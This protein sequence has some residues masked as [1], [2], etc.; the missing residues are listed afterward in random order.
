MV[1]ESDTCTRV[2]LMSRST[3]VEPGS[4]PR[5]GDRGAVL[6]ADGSAEGGRRGR[7]IVVS[8]VQSARRPR[9]ATTD[10]DDRAGPRRPDLRL[11][12]APGVR[13]VRV[14]DLP[15]PQS[16]PPRRP[17]RLRTPGE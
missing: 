13:G 9:P 4:C 12:P 3:Y 6:H 5:S 2:R 15:P 10:V 14:D 7:G 11:R 16:P 1:V 8:G 17:G